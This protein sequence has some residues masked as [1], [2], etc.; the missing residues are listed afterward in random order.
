MFGFGSQLPD[1]IGDGVF[2][3]IEKSTED[4]TDLGSTRWERT[5]EAEICVAGEQTLFLTGPFD[6][7]LDGRV[8]P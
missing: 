4:V 8:E 6:F 3:A 5:V 7:G 2:D 1:D